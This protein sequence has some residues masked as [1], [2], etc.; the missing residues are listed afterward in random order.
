MDLN[1]EFKDRVSSNPNRRK[2]T[3]VQQ[4]G[5]EMLVDMERADTNVTEQGTAINSAFLRNWND[6]I[7]HAV[8]QSNSAKTSAQN[9]QD[10]AQR[11]KT[12]ALESENKV[13]TAITN[14][15][16]A[17]GKA[18]QAYN[19]AVALTKDVDISQ[20]HGNGTPSVDLVTNSDGTKKFSF[21]NLKGDKGDKGD[22]G[23]A[24]G[25]GD[26]RA[27][28]V[29]LSAGATPYVNVQ[30][31]G[32]NTAKNVN[33]EFGIP[34][35]IQGIRG[36]KGDKGE[37]GDPAGFGTVDAV[38][39]ALPVG[40][41]PYAN[42]NTDGP[43]TAKNIHFD[44]GL[45]AGIQ[46]ERGEKGDCTYVRFSFDKTAM[47][48]EKTDNSIYIGFYNGVTPSSNPDD[49]QWSRMW[50]AKSISESD[51]SSLLRNDT[52][53]PEQIYFIEGVDGDNL[54][55]Y[56]SAD[57]IS[58]DD[59][60]SNL[61]AQNIQQAIDNIKAR[62]FSKSYNDLTDKP[63]IPTS[64]ESLTDKP[65]IPTNASFSLSGLSEKSYNSLT[66]KPF[67]P[68]NNS[69]TL[70]GLA[71]KSYNSLT[72]K[73]T[74]PVIDK[75]SIALALGL[76][77]YQLENLIELARRVNVNEENISFNTLSINVQE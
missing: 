57:E 37:I 55:V 1:L 8:E 28:T 43:N 29:S 77:E 12:S 15:N 64:Y 40:G 73:P 54:H 46:G 20:I 62:E 47:T 31:D 63:F 21:K 60:R 10:E 68:S 23:I 32:A 22:V 41:T 33:F 16:N 45:P 65:E 59:S 48:E 5:N 53:N 30:M 17:I 66:D 44:F 39:T 18:N 19:N 69:F 50:G 27:S 14:V 3:I 36:E 24:A 6:C 67:I 49:Y 25:F 35:G 75:S 52:L 34:S 56:Q 38:A 2:L 72:D 70:A 74:I 76:E 4:Q 51:Y 11:A 26:M 13:N 71:E 7:K 42:I 61:N 9:A 58:F